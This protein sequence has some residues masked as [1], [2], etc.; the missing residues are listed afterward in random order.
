[1]LLFQA[2]IAPCAR[3]LGRMMTNPTTPASKLSPAHCDVL[4]FARRALEAQL[5]DVSTLSS[6]HVVLGRLDLTTAAG[7]RLAV[8]SLHYHP[9]Y[10]PVT[11]ANDVALVQ[12]AAPAPSTFTPVAL[13]GDGE[14][15]VGHVE[16]VGS[17]AIVLGWGI[18]SDVALQF[19]SPVVA[20]TACD[21]KWVTVRRHC[22]APEPP[23]HHTHTPPDAPQPTS[24]DA[25]TCWLH[26]HAHSRCV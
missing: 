25:D 19:P 21:T 15:A 3:H 22:D 13:N 9:S 5:D 24:S 17:T 16:A 11:R 10:D 26:A 4:Q 18:M 23:M 7:T 20:T 12:V 2:Q 1:M 14:A 8:S 6:C